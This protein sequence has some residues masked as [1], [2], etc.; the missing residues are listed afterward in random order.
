MSDRARPSIALLAA[1][2]TSSSVLYGL[3]D[4]LLSV[5]AVY[6]DMTTG[7]PDESL[8][9]VKIVWLDA[10]MPGASDSVM[11]RRFIPSDQ[12]RRRP[13]RCPFCFLYEPN[14]V[15]R[16]AWP[17]RG[18]DALAQDDTAE[19]AN[20]VS[21]ICEP[22]SAA[23]TPAVQLFTVVGGVF[24]ITV[25]DNLPSSRY[26]CEALLPQNLTCSKTPSA[27]QQR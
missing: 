6:S 16:G 18:V 13:S 7:Q 9:D 11:M 21:P 26:N 3:Y 5:G 15:H 19:R 20:H 22:V 25:T 24:S 2:E 8:L 17:R 12:R 27:R 1:P 14:L 23:I 10:D 4:V